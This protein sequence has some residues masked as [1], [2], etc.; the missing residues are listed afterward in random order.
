MFLAL[1]IFFPKTLG[2]VDIPV[3]INN[4]GSSARIG[5]ITTFGIAISSITDPVLSTSTLMM[6]DGSGNVVDSEISVVLRWDGVSTDTAKY[7]KM[8]HVTFPASVGV[9][10]TKTYSLKTRTGADPGTF[11]LSVN[12]DASSYSI[13]TSS[14]VFNIR[15]DYFNLI[16]TA[17]VNGV[18]ILTPSTGRKISVIEKGV[19]YNS[20]NS[21][22]SFNIT[23]ERQ[24]PLWAVIRATGTLYSVSSSSA[25]LYDT[26][27]HF[28]ARSPVIK[29]QTTLIFDQDG[30]DFGPSSM[31]LLIPTSLSYPVDIQTPLASTT[32]RAGDYTYFLQYDNNIA[33]MSVNSTLVG[34]DQRPSGW[35]DVYDG[36]RGISV[37]KK[38]W[39][40]E[41]PSEISVLGN[42]I[43]YHFWPSDADYVSLVNRKRTAALASSTINQTWPYQPVSTFSLVGYSESG[44]SF[45]ESI[46]NSA[47]TSKTWEIG[48]SFYEAGMSSKSVM[49][50]MID[51][52]L[53]GIN[54]TYYTTSKVFGNVGPRI[55]DPGHYPLNHFDDLIYESYDYMLD[56]VFPARDNYGMF[57]YGDA[58]YDNS[59][60]NNRFWAMHRRNINSGPLMLFIRTGNRKYLDW[61][62]ANNRHLADVDMQHITKFFTDVR[63]N[64][65][66]KRKGAHGFTHD[67]G[68]AHWHN[69]AGAE[70]G[71]EPFVDAADIG[72]LWLYMLTA[73]LHIYDVVRE[74]YDELVRAGTSLYNTNTGTRNAATALST[75]R[76]Y[77]FTGDPSYL[78]YAN[79][80]FDSINRIRSGTQGIKDNVIGYFNNNENFIWNVFT[81]AWALDTVW[82]YA[83]LTKSTE[84]ANV[85]SIASKASLGMG[86]TGVSTG[87]RWWAAT[88]L[89]AGSRLYTNEGNVEAL[90]HMKSTMY[91]MFGSSI[92]YRTGAVNQ[93][94]TE[95]GFLAQN[96]PYAFKAITDFGHWAA[97]P[98]PRFIANYTIP[99]TYV[100]GSSVTYWLNEP[101]DRDWSVDYIFIPGTDYTDDFSATNGTWTVTITNPSGGTSL[102]QTFFVPGLVSGM[103]SGGTD[104]RKRRFSV[105]SDGLSGDYRVEIINTDGL[106]HVVSLAST[107]LPSSVFQTTANNSTS[108]MNRGVMYT[109]APAFS[110]FTAIGPGGMTLFD[111]DDNFYS[112]VT[113]GLVTNHN[114]TNKGGQFFGM[115]A[116]YIDNDL[117]PSGIQFYKIRQT[118]SVKPLI[119][120][121]P[122][123]YHDVSSVSPIG[124]AETNTGVRITNTQSGPSIV[125]DRAITGA[126]KNVAF[127]KTLTAFAGTSPY[128]WSITGGALP[129]GLSLSSDGTISGT[130]TTIGV[131]TTTIQVTD[132][133][134]QSTSR[135]FGMYVAAGSESTPASSPATNRQLR[136]RG[137]FRGRVLF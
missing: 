83:E 77:Q 79:T 133:A 55:Y 35:L 113:A 100:S 43:A 22:P 78:S 85:A 137:T 16:D 106:N 24:G 34:S 97:I 33:S 58:Q 18:N 84:A 134:A 119:S 11:S 20:T 23:L 124:S 41:Y 21:D 73:D 132:N 30:Y 42:T 28:Y 81:M 68:N 64:T 2:A 90:S 121:S 94:H 126:Q 25:I 5:E 9:G 60:P 71:A 39:W 82:D 135:I 67:V 56:T 128:T 75:I 37:F 51:K 17:T 123:Q 7:I 98:K 122:Q 130:P 89:I 88:P 44:A 93:M 62:I 69:L 31:T 48:M 47:G 46:N 118:S 14:A 91:T 32:T 50:D 10:E 101:T 136:S 63:G 4:D 76:G 59:S 66:K 103:I 74:R 1:P 6:T 15:R 53:F 27:M 99:P 61:A 96:A 13:N 110:S 112:Y 45:V 117:G 87:D 108:V 95:F 12:S 52:P 120:M 131:S 129:A 102:S 80:N 105:A 29:V 26:R 107:T 8:V 38:N 65:V 125:D 114:V 109:Y 49:A 111:Q 19:E 54:T 57:V 40:Q 127:S 115:T 92:G 3:Y 36:S 70:S 72:F 116:R 104:N 86:D